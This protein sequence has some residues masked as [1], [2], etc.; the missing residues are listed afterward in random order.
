M[1]VIKKGGKRGLPSVSTASLPDIIFTLLFFFIVTG[2]VKE[3]GLK[4]DT[5]LPQAVDT[6]KL[7]K[8]DKASYIYVGKPKPAYQNVYGSEAVVQLADKIARN[9]KEV[10][11]FVYFERHKLPY[12]KRPS[13]LISMKADRDVPYDL[14]NNIKIELRKA[15]A[16]RLNYDSNSKSYD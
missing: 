1:A 13:H 2:K 4:V 10:Q 8:K 9:P 6:K 16:L 3:S 7:P 11:E 12:D 15:E 14:I 5:K